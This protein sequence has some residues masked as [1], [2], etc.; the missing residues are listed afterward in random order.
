MLELSRTQVE[1][2]E[3]NQERQFARASLARMTAQM[4]DL[5][6]DIPE[7]EAVGQGV[8][9]IRRFAK[10]DFVRSP[11]WLDVILWLGWIFGEDRMQDPDIAQALSNTAI[12]PTER[13][14]AATTLAFDQM[15][16]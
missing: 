1:A 14:K 12:A 7:Q 10:S 11:D 16:A 6:P 2:F 13:L 3:R 8:R 4:P 9:L 15:R 5:V